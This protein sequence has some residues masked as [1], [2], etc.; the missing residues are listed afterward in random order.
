MICWIHC[1]LKRC[2]QNHTLYSL[3]ATTII[4]SGI[5]VIVAANMEHLA[6][7]DSICLPNVAKRIIIVIIVRLKVDG[8]R[9]IESIWNQADVNLSVDIKEQTEKKKM[10]IKCSNKTNRC[11]V[12][13][14][15]RICT[16]ISWCAFSYSFF[17]DQCVSIKFNA[18]FFLF[19]FFCFSLA[20]FLG[21][22]N[23]K[24]CQ[25][26]FTSKSGMC[27]HMRYSCPAYKSSAPLLQC[28][29]C[30]H[31]CRRPDNMRA[32]VMRHH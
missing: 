17:F 27:K 25:K 19:F 32:H 18:R 23:C 5:V 31:F 4:G 9:I 22:Y 13:L 11:R 12:S 2:K 6:R 8:N 28:S 20:D 29:F 21:F 3:T 7:F 14:E 16:K 30:P 10:K 24:Y 15:C 26:S 1:I